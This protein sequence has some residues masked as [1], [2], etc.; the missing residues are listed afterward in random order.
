MNEYLYRINRLKCAYNGGNP[1][2]EIDKLSIPRGKIMFLLGV[3]GSGKSTFLETLGL[4]NHTIQDGEL[5]FCPEPAMPAVEIHQLWSQNKQEQLAEIRNRHLSFIFQNTNLMPNFTALENI[6]ITSMIQGSSFDDAKKISL[7]YLEQVGLHNLQDR[8]SNMFSGGERQRIAFV[9]AI[10][11]NFS[12]LFGDEPTG[13]L[14]DLNAGVLLDFLKAKVKDSGKS[15]IIVSHHID[16]AIKHAD[17]IYVLTKESKTSPG[18][19]TEEVSFSR[20]GQHDDTE[21]ACQWANHADESITDI[22]ESI[23]RHLRTADENR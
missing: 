20:T 15:A 17:I 11:S 1:V 3:S 4:M 16:L 14:D 13:N 21:P 9:R 2:L 5:F 8:P 18:K 10:N 19:I 6:C 7:E 12:V 22:K 23:R